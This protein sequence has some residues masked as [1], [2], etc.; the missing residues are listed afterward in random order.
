MTYILYRI[1]GTR[2]FSWTT[3]D[4][5]HFSTHDIAIAHS[6]EE[7]NIA[8]NMIQEQGWRYYANV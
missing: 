7:M 1:P 8:L 5:Y 4:D 6:R 2:L 3:T